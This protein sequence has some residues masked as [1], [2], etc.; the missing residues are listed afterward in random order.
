MPVATEIRGGPATNGLVTAYFRK[1]FRLT[2]PGLVRRLT[3][4]L[5]C[6]DGAVV[7]LNG[8]EVHRRN[9]PAGR[10]DAFTAAIADITGVGE[11]VA[12]PFDIPDPQ[13]LLRTG[14]NLVAVEVH[15]AAKAQGEPDLRFEFE[16]G[17]N[18]NR[19]NEPPFVLL[20]SLPDA[21]LFRTDSPVE[22]EA[23]TA[24]VDGTVASVEIAI[25]GVK[26][27][28][29]DRPPFRYRAA[30]AGRLPPD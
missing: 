26:V 15:Q 6:D 13:R 1:T 24:D 11:L 30:A 17:A 25:D 9:L 4:R 8:T 3:L 21:G 20:T 2:D 12:H 18:S 14:D 7:Y 5:Q 16:L 10:V 28:V 23:D 27:A 22:I 19:D 29:L